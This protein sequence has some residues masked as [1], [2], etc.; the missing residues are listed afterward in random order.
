M[1]R[2]IPK[3]EAVF[4]LGS[5][6][7]GMHISR[8]EGHNVRLA[9]MGSESPFVGYIDLWEDLDWLWPERGLSSAARRMVAC[10]KI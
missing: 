7:I 1:D 9:T 5:A 4:A 8:F 2:T 10:H 6:Y 3:E